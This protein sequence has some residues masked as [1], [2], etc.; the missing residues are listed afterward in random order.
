MMPP[1][2]QD[3]LLAAHA[4]MK[5]PASWTFEA[6]MRDPLRSRVVR[7][8]A[9]QMRAKER[10]QTVRTVRRANSDGQRKEWPPLEEPDSIGVF[11]V[12]LSIAIWAAM[13]FMAVVGILAVL[14]G[15]RP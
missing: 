15:F 7:A 14:A 11:M 5:W 8:R 10:S 12:A 4:A 13:A 2:T 3:Q 1:L 9:A 6:A